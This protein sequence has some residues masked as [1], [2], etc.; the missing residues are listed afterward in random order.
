MSDFIWETFDGLFRTVQRQDK[1]AS[2]LEARVAELERRL[3]ERS[4]LKEI[5]PMQATLATEREE[6]ETKRAA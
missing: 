2:E 3:N 1:R 5:A 6:F 4:A